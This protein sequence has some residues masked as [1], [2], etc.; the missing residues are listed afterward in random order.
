MRATFPTRLGR[1][2][3]LLTRLPPAVYAEPAQAAQEVGL[4]D[5]VNISGVGGDVV[6]GV[7]KGTGNIVG[8]E[9]TVSG[10]VTVNPDRLD[11][12]APEYAQSLQAFAEGLNQRL[13]EQEVPPEQ[14]AEVNESVDALAAEAEDLPTEEPPTEEKKRGI[15]QRLAGVGRSLLKVLPD[16]AEAVTALT[17][18]A[19]FGKIIGKAVDGVVAAVQDE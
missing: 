7:V 3:R 10:T 4:M 1:P 14:M 9:V 13:A 12:M 6:G 11:R 8:K 15:W 17:P 2:I 5:E 19:P 18:L 16:A